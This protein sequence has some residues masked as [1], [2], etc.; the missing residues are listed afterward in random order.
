LPVQLEVLFSLYPRRHIDTV[1]VSVIWPSILLP[2]ALVCL[3][4]WKG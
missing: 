1:V 3:L 2:T 4:A